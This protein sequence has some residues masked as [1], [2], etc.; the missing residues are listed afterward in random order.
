MT[1]CHIAQVFLHLGP[2]FMHIHL[3]HNG[4]HLFKNVTSLTQVA[5][6]VCYSIPLRIVV[7]FW[8]AGRLKVRY[9]VPQ[10]A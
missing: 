8:G 3:Q 7:G 2:L 5:A 4:K 9:I 6:T 10:I 1:T